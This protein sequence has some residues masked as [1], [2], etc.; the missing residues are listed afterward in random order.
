M[1]A[2]LPIVFVLVTDPEGSG[3]VQSLGRPGF[4]LTGFSTFAASAG[5]KW[6]ALLK[7]AAPKVSWIALLFNPETAP[8]DEG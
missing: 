5:A 8:F 3:F 4:N 1:R 2:V 6:L 7:E